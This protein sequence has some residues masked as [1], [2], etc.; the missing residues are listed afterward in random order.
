VGS[1]VGCPPSF[2]ASKSVYRTLRQAAAKAR[3]YAALGQ[4][5]AQIDVPSS[6][7]IRYERTTHQRGHY[8][9]WGEPNT[10]LTL[11]VTV[12]PANETT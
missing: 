5:I 1:V 2:A 8:T 3:R 4:F 6:S 10:L 7:E 9:L 12:F 11:V